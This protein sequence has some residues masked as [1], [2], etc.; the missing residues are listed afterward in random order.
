MNK[1]TV[2]EWLKAH[3]H[4]REWLAEKCGVNVRTV[5]N[6][7][8][9]VGIPSKAAVII[10]SLMT[11]DE[12][13]EQAKSAVPQNLVLEWDLTDAKEREDYENIEA[14]AVDSGLAIREWALEK[15]RDSAEI[16]NVIEAFSKGEFVH[17]LPFLGA[18]AAGEPVEAPRDEVLRVDREWPEGHF[19]VE[20]NGQSME[21]DFVDGD[22]WIIDGRKKYTPKN[23][24]VCVVSDGHGSYLKRWNRKEG[25]FE[26]INPEFK[27]VISGE[28]AK[29]QGYPVERVNS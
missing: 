18:V 3:N 22:R 1:E 12:V 4:S 10:Q 23:G 2:N 17:D 8:T 28:E 7:L 6:W 26:S 16:G 20:V 19:V 29:L 5:G 24:A 21:P 25:V 15:L 9:S 14:A 13:N 11:T 27:D